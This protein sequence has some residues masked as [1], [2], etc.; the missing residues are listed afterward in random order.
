MLEGIS[1]SSKNE[2]DEADDEVFFIST[3]MQSKHDETVIREREQR[4]QKVAL[5]KLQEFKNDNLGKSIGSLVSGNVKLEPRIKK[6]TKTRKKTKSLNSFTNKSKSGHKSTSALVRDN[7][8]KSKL[9]PYFSGDQTKISDFMLK[10]KKMEDLE[11]LIPKVSLKLFSQLE[12]NHILRCIKLKFP[13]LTSTRK[14]NL[15]LITRK[16]NEFELEHENEPGIWSQASTQPNSKLDHEELKWLYDLTDDQ[17]VNNTSFNEDMDLGNDQYVMVLSQ[18][19]T[20]KGNRINKPLENS[21]I[22]IVL[23]SE[24]EPEILTT[25]DI[26]S[27]QVESILDPL[28]SFQSFPFAEV[29]TA[30]FKKQNLKDDSVFEVITSLQLVDYTQ[31]SS[32]DPEDCHIAIASKES[33]NSEIN[34]SKLFKEFFVSSEEYSR[35]T[36]INNDKTKEKI[37]DENTPIKPDSQN[38]AMN[39]L[40]HQYTERSHSNQLEIIESPHKMEVILSSSKASPYFSPTKVEVDDSPFKTPTKR[41]KRLLDQISSPQMFSES[42]II[43]IKEMGSPIKLPKSSPVLSKQNVNNSSPVHSPPSVKMP[44]KLVK[45]SSNLQEEDEEGIVSTSESIYSTAKSQLPSQYDTPHIIGSSKKSKQKLLNTTRYEIRSNINFRECYIHETKTEVRK[46]GTKVIDL[47][48]DNEIPDSEDEENSISI[49]EVVREIDPVQDVDYEN[50]QGNTSVLQIPSSP[51]VLGN[52]KPEESINSLT[53]NQISSQLSQLS[54]K[55]L[56]SKIIEWGLKPVK[57][58][59]KMVQV[60]DETSKLIVESSQLTPE[61]QFDVANLFDQSQTSQQIK[62]NINIALNH[63]IKQDQYWYEKIISYDPIKAEELQEWLVSIGYN[64]ELDI[65]KRYCD[66]IGITTRQ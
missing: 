57:S 36:E 4:L 28:V 29:K 26:S 15:K 18:N 23:D 54:T 42:E 2:N 20:S 33:S 11:N 30:D 35:Q 63:V 61:S 53:Q 50:E 48:L 6:V 51:A 43:A 55:Q 27:R 8:E 47:D 16:I 1:S 5:T 64:I 25:R 62:N 10:I 3:Q 41:S 59:A 45:Y 24:L 34:T 58:R 7:Y 39:S 9:F 49:I 22:E 56:K 17:M 12:W 44:V 19:D 14:K 37:L 31:K 21:V 40:L 65:V 60:L 13:N 38:I 32:Q 46:I 52:I 66:D